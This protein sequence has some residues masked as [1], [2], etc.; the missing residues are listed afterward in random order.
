MPPDTSGL[1]AN[2]IILIIG[3]VGTF[4][5]M[6]LV[7]G[8]IMIVKA[9][10]ENTSTLNAVHRLTNS[11]HTTSLQLVADATL[12]T[13]QVTGDPDDIKLHKSA[14]KALDLAKTATKE[15]EKLDDAKKSG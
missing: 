9:V 5:S 1:S 15:V 3:A 4:V 2:E 11:Q 14:E 12:K 6:A 13:A 8:I 7:P 10:K